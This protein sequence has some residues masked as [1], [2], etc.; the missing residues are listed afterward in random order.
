MP[1]A[2]LGLRHDLF[3]IC[4]LCKGFSKYHNTL[5][6]ESTFFLFFMYTGGVMQLE[7][8]GKGGVSGLSFFPSRIIC[9]E[10]EMGVLVVC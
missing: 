4:L 7:V 3:F 5:C 1:W 10:I 2:R 9:T 6:L 8:W